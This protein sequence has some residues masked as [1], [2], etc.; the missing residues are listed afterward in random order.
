VL[1]LLLPIIPAQRRAHHLYVKNEADEA[2]IPTPNHD[3]FVLVCG[4]APLD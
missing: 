3:D 2:K 4:G 1:L